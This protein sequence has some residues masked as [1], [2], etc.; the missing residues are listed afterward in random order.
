VLKLELSHDVG[1]KLRYSEFEYA[2]DLDALYEAIG[3]EP[4]R[5]QGAWDQGHCVFPDNHANGDQTGKFGINRDE[6]IYNCWVC[7]GGDLVS[8]AMEWLNGA[9]SPPVNV[10]DATHWL[11]QFTRGVTE[12]KFLDE[13]EKDLIDVEQRAATL[14]FFNSRVLDKWIANLQASDDMLYYM[15]TKWAILPE[16]AEEAKVGYDPNHS[17]R[18]GDE[19]YIGPALI[20]PV[21]WKDRLVGWQD[22]W[23]EPKENRPKWVPKYTNTTDMPKTDVIYGYDEALRGPLRK[24]TVFTLESSPSVLSLRSAGL[25]AVGTFGTSINEPQ[26]RLLRRFTQGVALCPD[27][28]PTPPPKREG[29]KPKMPAGL[30][31]QKQC[32]EYLQDFVPVYLMPVPPVDEKGDVADL[33]A[34]H[35]SRFMEWILGA[36]DP[37]DDLGSDT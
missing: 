1:K 13:F 11:H 14:P 34:K 24:A 29:N 37:L 35:P 30:K 28:D 8:L 15:W 16:I 4:V 26:L 22:R 10:D 36:R 20:F 9:D 32:A 27:N 3:F 6:R 33:L 19:V 18:V 23:L 5:H 7:G 12:D 17:R 21:F 25:N 31:W 2:I